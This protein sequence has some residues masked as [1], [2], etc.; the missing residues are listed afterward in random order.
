MAGQRNTRPLCGNADSHKP[1]HFF[2]KKDGKIV[3]VDK[4]LIGNLNFFQDEKE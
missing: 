4:E 1:I 3:M 2:T